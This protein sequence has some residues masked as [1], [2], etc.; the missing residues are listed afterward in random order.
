[1]SDFRTLCCS[2]ILT[3]SCSLFPITALSNVLV[4]QPLNFGK[5]AITSNATAS[6]TSLRRNG[7]QTSTN[8]ILIVEKGMPAILQLSNFPIYATIS[9]SAVTP[10][11]SSM[12]YAGSEQF[13]ITALDMPA[14]LNVNGLGEA[15][16]QVG[17]TLATSGL[18]GGYY[19]DAVYHIY[20]DIEFSY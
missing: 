3:F 2:S 11:S 5:I 14:S 17:G 16:L 13:T 9:L 8:K 4:S 18:G 20:I 6:T 7:S 10:V 19:N 1:M 12:P 15:T